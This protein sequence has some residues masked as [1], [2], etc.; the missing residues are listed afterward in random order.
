MIAAAVASKSFVAEWE[1]FEARR[2]EQGFRE[3]GA[4]SYGAHSISHPGREGGRKRGREG[5]R[6]IGGG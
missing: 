2:G 1:T 5:G 6:E 3:T 4:G